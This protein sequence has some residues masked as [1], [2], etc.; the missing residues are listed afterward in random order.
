VFERTLAEAGGDPVPRAVLADLLMMVMYG[1]RE[2]TE[3]E[4]RALLA[5]SGFRHTRTV[6]T[7]GGLAVMEAVREGGP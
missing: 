3:A 2:R 5:A 1:G 7:A 4:Y 6:P